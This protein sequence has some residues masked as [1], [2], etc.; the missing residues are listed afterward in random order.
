VPLE[1]L[2]KKFAYQRFE[3]SGFTK[4]PDIRTPRRSLDLVFAGSVASSSAVTRKRLAEQGPGGSPMR[5][6]P[7]LTR[8]GQPSVPELAN[9][10]PSLIDV[11][12]QKNGS[13]GA[14]S[15]PFRGH[16]HA[17]P[18]AGSLG[19]MYMDITCSTAVR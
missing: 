18:R 13:E 4:N 3:P 19:N 10:S 14:S 15:H 2:V 1:S 6:L 11:I 8:R 17:E 12:T 7:K 5:N 9:E 16:T